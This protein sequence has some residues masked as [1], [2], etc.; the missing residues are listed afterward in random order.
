MFKIVEDYISNY[1]N[2]ETIDSANFSQITEIYEILQQA[3][4]MRS[5]MLHEKRNRVKAFIDI[6]QNDSH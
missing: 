4:N 2:K 1:F 3:C 6:L 5:M